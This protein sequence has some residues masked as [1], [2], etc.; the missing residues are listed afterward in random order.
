MQNGRQAIIRNNYN[1]MA[2][3]YSISW[4]MYLLDSNIICT[5]DKNINSAIASE[6]KSADII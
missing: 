4:I 3:L 6:D 5:Y 1:E 2:L